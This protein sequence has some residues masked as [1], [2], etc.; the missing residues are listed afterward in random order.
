MPV[1]HPSIFSTLKI[2]KKP[3]GMLKG[4]VW[5]ICAQIFNLDIFKNGWDNI[6]HVFSRHFGTL[7]TDIFRILFFDRYWRFKVFRV[8]FK[9]FA[10]I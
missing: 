6:K 3:Y 4:N 5:L 10:K 7:G 9:L 1:L 2:F 8:I